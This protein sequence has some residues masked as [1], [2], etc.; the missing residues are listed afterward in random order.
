MGLLTLY[1][2]EEILL[3][4]SLKAT[5]NWLGSSKKFRWVIQGHLGPLDK[6]L[7]VYF[8]C[9]YLSLKTSL[10][11]CLPVSPLPLLSLFLSLQSVCCLVSRLVGRS[12][13]LPCLCIWVP[14]PFCLELFYVIVLCFTAA[15][16]E[17]TV[18]VCAPLWLILLRFAVEKVST[19]SG[20]HRA[21]VVS[22][23]EKIG[24]F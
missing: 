21:C 5:K 23:V 3:N 16:S 13:C 4:S 19:S 20:V 6:P 11:L 8:Y 10:S 14:K 1:G 12:D 17:G 15:I 2:H 9:F 22:I 7:S 18:N 24:L